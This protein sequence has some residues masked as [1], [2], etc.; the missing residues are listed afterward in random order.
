MD[1]KRKHVVKRQVPSLTDH[2]AKGIRVLDAGC[3]C[4][5]ILSRLAALEPRSRFLDLDLSADAITYARE[6]A[7]RAGLDNVE[8]VAADQNGIQGLP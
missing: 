5:R 1:E 3:G 4:G 7:S 8:F 2:L 6:E